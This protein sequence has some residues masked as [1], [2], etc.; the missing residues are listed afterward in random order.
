MRWLLLFLLLCPSARAAEELPLGP[1]GARGKVEA[2]SAELT[3]VQLEPD[4]P[5]ARAGLQVA[6]RIVGVGGVT[7]TPHTADVDDGGRG[8]Q[9]ALG[10]ALDSHSA[11][12]TPEDRRVRLDVRRGEES[13]EIDVALPHRPSVA[14]R[15]GRDALI[16]SARQQLLAA[17]SEAGLWDSPVGLSGDRVTTAWA[18]MALLASSKDEDRDSLDR[19]ARWLRGPEG[20]AW[21]PDDPLQKGPDN[22]GNWAITATAVALAEHQLRTGDESNRPVLTRCTQALV[23]RMTDDGLFGHDVGAGYTGK[24][25]NV[26]NT[27][28]HLA[29][30]AAADAGVPIEEPAWEK[31]LEQIRRSIDPNGGVRYWT[32][33]G[34]GTSDASLR[35]SS[36]AI[37]LQLAGREPELTNRL[38]EYLKGHAARARESHAVGSMG[39]ML[40]PAALW[41]FDA[42]AYGRFLEEWRWY[43]CLMQ[44]P[45][46]RVSY[47]GGK[48]N[49]GGDSYLGFD[50]ISCIIALLMLS[51][52][53]ELLQIH[54]RQ[55]ITLEPGK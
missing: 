10:E 2:G 39:M 7:F 34:T 1:L 36:M 17:Q 20:K 47:I 53:L 18:L 35:T 51:P 12:A 9:K 25:F 13:L 6:D 31:S 23:A 29:W 3:L 32:M 19:A 43:L 41:H 26:I 21:I 38:C 30:A 52:P 50:D 33:E 15:E 11:H 40:T 16:Q 24:G 44:E 27:L 28:S 48:G 46:G 45:G 55:Q 49:N 14:S 54:R 8:P 5:A 22:L 4:A 37:A 42:V